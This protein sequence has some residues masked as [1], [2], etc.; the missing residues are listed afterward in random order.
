MITQAWNS[1]G[2]KVLDDLK[3]HHL[4]VTVDGTSAAALYD[5]GNQVATT[6]ISASHGID[7]CADATYCYQLR[8]SFWCWFFNGSL[9]RTRFYNK[10]LTQA[11]VDNAYQRADVDFDEQYGS[12]TELS[13]NTFVNSGFA[14][15]SGNAGG[16]TTSG[17]ASGN[18]AYKNQSFTGGKKYRLKFTLADG[19]SSNL[20]LLFRSLTGGAGAN[21]GK[22]DSSNLGTIVSGT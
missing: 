7:S 8:P 16:F 17:S 4:V 9:Y 2:V 15:F 1:F 14:G 19:N 20:L 6:T 13:T 18:V 11:E 10:T 5:N 21:V 22:I 3:V 12:Q